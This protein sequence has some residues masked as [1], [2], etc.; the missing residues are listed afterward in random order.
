MKIM[1]ELTVQHGLKAAEIK[2]LFALL[3]S[4]DGKMECSPTAG[5]I[6]AMCGISRSCVRRAVRSLEGKGLLTREAQYYEDEPT[7][8]AANKYRLRFEV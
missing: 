3:L 7:A 1:D 5:E 4:V 2:V 8:R 6:A